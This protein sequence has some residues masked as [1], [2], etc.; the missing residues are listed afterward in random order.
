MNLQQHKKVFIHY[1][2]NKRAS[3]F[4]ALYLVVSDEMSL[5]QGWNLILDVWEPNLVWESYYYEMLN[6]FYRI[7]EEIE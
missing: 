2:D 3:V 5:T 7:Q 1:E 6:Q 4:V